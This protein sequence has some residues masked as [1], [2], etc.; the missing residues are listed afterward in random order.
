MAFPLLAEV[1]QRAAE[2]PDGA[3]PLGGEFEGHLVQGGEMCGVAPAERDLGDETRGP[4]QQTARRRVFG[5]KLP[6]AIERAPGLLDHADSLGH[7]HEGGRGRDDSRRGERQRVAGEIR[8]G[9]RQETAQ[10]V[11]EDEGCALSLHLDAAAPVL[12]LASQVQGVHE[13]DQAALLHA[14]PQRQQRPGGT[15]RAGKQQSDPGPGFGRMDEPRRVG[16]LPLSK[17]I[18]P[19]VAHHLNL[20][21]GNGDLSERPDGV[22]GIQEGR[23]MT[24]QLGGQPQ[25]GLEAVSEAGRDQHALGHQPGRA[26]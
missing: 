14:A 7:G 5:R 21:A 6:M 20:A 10:A 16:R 26:V 15:R 24:R 12:D 3:E 2:R 11:V 13:F 22:R 23:F 18:R 8:G 25:L 9:K 17:A 4:R 19:A 1:A